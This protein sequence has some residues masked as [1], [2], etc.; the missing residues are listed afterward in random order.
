MK[1][2]DLKFKSTITQEQDSESFQKIAKAQVE[3]LKDGWRLKYLEDNQIPVKILLKKQKQTLIINRGVV[4][5]NYSLIKLELGEKRGCK[6]VVNNR[7]MD[8]ISETKFL[9]V[10]KYG[11]RTKVQVE[12]DLFSGLYLIGNYAVTLIFS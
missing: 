12:Y 10:T 3:E 5:S 8:L 2:V 9:K 7:Q 6:Y 11:G 1:E 4:P